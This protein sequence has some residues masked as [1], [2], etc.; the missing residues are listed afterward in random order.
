VRA[1][2]TTRKPGIRPWHER[3]SPEHLAELEELRG[4]WRVGRLGSQLKPVAV[5]VVAYLHANQISDIGVQ[6]V[7]K[8]LGQRD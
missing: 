6:G 7:I 1:N 3:L 4:E 5:E 2:L 8:W